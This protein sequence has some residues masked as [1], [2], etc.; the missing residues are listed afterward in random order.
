MN[1][2]FNVI[3]HVVLFLLVFAVGDC[4]STGADALVRKTPPVKIIFDTDIGNDVD[5]GLALAMLHAL[6]TRDICELLAVT[7]TKPD[8][9]AGPFVNAINTFYDRPNIPIGFTHAGLVNQ[10][11]NVLQLVTVEDDGHFRFPHTLL[12]SSDAPEATQLL[13]S[14]LS[15]QPDDSVILVQVGFFSNYAALL[16][17]LG[18]T[19]SPLTGCE[20]VKK[21]VK[22]LSV[23]AG[24][25]QT[26]DNN[27]HYLEY[28]VYNDLPSARK[29][30]AKWPTPIVWSGFEVGYAIK[31][32]AQ[33]IEHDYGYV[34][35]HPISESYCRYLP[36][37][38][39]RPAWDL[40]A[41]LYA[42]CP[43]YGYFNLSQPGQVCMGNDGFTRFVPSKGG[44]DRFLIVNE[45]QIER[46]KEALVQLASQPPGVLSR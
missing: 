10:P 22:L 33:S 40:T 11:G 17:T 25:F 18:D 16:G 21:K 1:E 41:T 36:M 4:K 37:P 9:L 13:R 19:N 34:L 24:A 38:Y 46:V 44:R 28:N 42:V 45:T 6:Q 5:D 43:D 30:V 39:D 15:R 32:P 3:R 14:I 35:H 12:R 2:K 7:I 29:L 8:E 23:M 26:I 20:L 31:Y 27:N